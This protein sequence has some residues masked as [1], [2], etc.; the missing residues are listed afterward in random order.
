MAWSGL[1]RTVQGE[2]RRLVGVA[3]LSWCCG[4]SHSRYATRRA[5]RLRGNGV[6]PFSIEPHKSVATVHALPV[7]VHLARL[8]VVSATV[9]AEPEIM[10]GSQSQEA[11]GYG[12]PMEIIR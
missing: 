4:G 3:A 2:A 12:A 8:G 1:Q 5:A 6:E 10:I 7:Q 11:E 9:I